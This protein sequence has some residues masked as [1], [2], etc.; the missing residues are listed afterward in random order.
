SEE[1]AVEAAQETL[2]AAGGQVSCALVFASS[3]YRE[4]LPDFLELI[5][6]HGHVPTL[7]GC[8]GAGLIADGLEAEG[9]SG[10]SLLF[11]NLP[12]TQLIPFSFSQASVE[13]QCEPREWQQQAGVKPGEVDAWVTIGNP[14]NLPLEDWLEQWNA[15]F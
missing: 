8:S 6:V 9:V 7:V 3:D 10:F 4:I 5:Q 13:A 15:A 11:L 1:K 2:A 14:I 12:N